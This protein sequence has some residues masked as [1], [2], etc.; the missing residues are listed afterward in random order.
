MN[1]L[2]RNSKAT[3]KLPVAFPFVYLPEPLPPT[4]APEFAFGPVPTV[5]PNNDSM[6]TATRGSKNSTIDKLNRRQFH[7]E[8]RHHFFNK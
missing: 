8:L 5:E 3:D 4:E 1:K 6:F 7:L 2:R